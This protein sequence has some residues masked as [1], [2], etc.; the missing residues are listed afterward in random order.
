MR[1]ISETLH[2][3]TLHSVYPEPQNL[4]LR[5]A[6]LAGVITQP[7]VFSSFFFISLEPRVA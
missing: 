1:A 4:Y 2:F 7:G 6:M 5:S 3:L